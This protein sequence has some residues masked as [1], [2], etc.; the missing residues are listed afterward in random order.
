MTAATRFAV[1]RIGDYCSK[2]CADARWCFYCGRF[3]AFR[4]PWGGSSYGD[5]RSAIARHAHR[6]PTRLARVAVALD[7][8]G[9]FGMRVAD[10]IDLFA[11]WRAAR[12]LR[13][14]RDAETLVA[15]RGT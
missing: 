14:A 11:R 9:P 8:R 5:V 4:A 1:P 3:V 6:E 13:R 2:A 15:V 10:A 7:R 12:A